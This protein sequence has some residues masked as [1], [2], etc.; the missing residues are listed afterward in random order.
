MPIALLTL[1]SLQLILVAPRQVIIV[2]GPAKPVPNG[3][4]IPASRLVNWTPGTHTGVPG[5]IPTNRTQCA[6]TECQAVTNAD[7]GYKDRTLDAKPLLQAAVDS[8]LPNT[9]V[10]VP[11]GT[12]RLSSVVTIGPTKDSITLRGSGASTILDCS[13][14]GQYCVFTGSDAD[15]LWTSPSSNNTILSY[16]NG[17]TELTIADASTFATSNQLLQFT[18]ANDPSIPVINTSGYPNARKQMTRLVSKSSN[19]ITVFPPIYHCELFASLTARVNKSSVQSDFIGLEDL[20]VDGTNGSVVFGINVRQCYGCWVKNVTT[21]AANNYQLSLTDSVQIEVRHSTIGPGRTGGSNGAGILTE[22]LTAFLIEDNILIESHPIIETNFGTSGGVIAYNF[23]RNGNGA[24]FGFD[25][26]HGPHNSFNIYEGNICHNLISDS[27][28]GSASEETVFRNY[29]HGNGEPGFGSSLASFCLA[30]KRLTRNPT[31]I[32][33]VIGGSLWAV[34]C[35]GTY[36]NPNIGN[37]NSIGTAQP[38]QSDPWAH[39]TPSGPTTVGTLTTRTSDTAGSV[40]LTGGDLTTN[41]GGGQCDAAAMWTAANALAP[42]CQ[43]N[44]TGAVGNVVSFTLMNGTLPALNTAV[45]I[46]P[47]PLGFQER[48]LDVEATLISKANWDVRTSTM[49]GSSLN[50]AI[51]P[52]SLVYSARP[53]WLPASINWPPI[54]YLSPSTNRAAIPA[55]HRYLNAG[56]DPP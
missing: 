15:Y 6:T 36:G 10:V 4:L 29:L 49:D 51:V 34:A 13:L 43:L 1:L 55:G 44:I 19:T 11:A 53:T 30:F 46:W 14:S 3:E 7:I 35:Y 23:C 12:W 22:T 38:S 48:D 40:T 56:S 27:Y 25:T 18:V 17:C 21:K 5:G 39:W 47:G 20:T 54:N 32:G 52:P 42:C 33:N 28:F 31:L 37:G 24:D 50:G 8:A 45:T 41:C 9:V 2:A 26:N 16:G